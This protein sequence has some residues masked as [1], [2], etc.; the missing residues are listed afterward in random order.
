MKITILNIEEIY[1]KIAQ[2]RDAKT[3]LKSYTASYEDSQKV[4]KDLE[5]SAKAA[6]DNKQRIVNNA[7]NAY[8]KA[9]ANYNAA[10]NN[11]AEK[12]K[13]YES[14]R[15]SEGQQKTRE[16]RY[17]WVEHKA[18]ESNLYP[19]ILY[20]LISSVDPSKLNS[21]SRTMSPET[22][23]CSS[24]KFIDY[25]VITLDNPPRDLGYDTRLKI[26][27][28]ETNI[29]DTNSFKANMATTVA[30]AFAY[31]LYPIT[32]D[33]AG[34]IASIGATLTDAEKMIRDTYS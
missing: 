34:A 14:I 26:K 25:W 4:L 13:A 17:T 10:V 2:Y 12:A 29:H 9:V 24:S 22:T 3:N 23:M 16:S 30:G 28:Y 7:K 33:Q 19:N 31:S 15:N 21:N 18:D 32:E 27:T 5:K 20:N 11:Q 8:D 6:L 1:S